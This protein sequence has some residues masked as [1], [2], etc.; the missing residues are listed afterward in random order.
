MSFV[1]HEFSSQYLPGGILGNRVHELHAASESVA[2][3]NLL[4][5][6]TRY[7]G[8][9][10][11]TSWHNES[12]GQLAGLLVWDADDGGV[13]YQL[14]RQQHRLQLRGSNLKGLRT[15]PDQQGGW[16][17]QSGSQVAWD[18]IVRLM[19]SLIHRLIDWLI[20]WLMNV[21]LDGLTD[22]LVG[23]SVLWLVDW[24]LASLFHWSVDWLFDWSINL[25]GGQLIGFFIEWLIDTFIDQ[26]ID[27]LG[28]LI[29]WFTHWFMA[30]LLELVI[31][32]APSLIDCS[33]DRVIDWLTV[34]A[35]G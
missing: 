17:Q 9:C 22:C 18:V 34:T 10:H 27:W 23:W 14:V 20:D 26:S 21:L 29:D 28:Y 31:S 3:R 25:L 2:R 35:T 19:K 4:V 15:K 6:K 33:I 5:D 32:L 7:F 11:V 30:L 16:G 24:L 12:F 13:G 1:L 8:G